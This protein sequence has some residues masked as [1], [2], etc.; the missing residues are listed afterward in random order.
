MEKF[1]YKAN[2]ED[3]FTDTPLGLL[4]DQKVWT[5]TLQGF[6]TLINLN[7]ST[8]VNQNPYRHQ[9]WLDEIMQALEIKS[10]KLSN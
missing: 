7:N 5:P 1:G 3:F 9:L 10:T 4:E 8:G 6:K 2:L